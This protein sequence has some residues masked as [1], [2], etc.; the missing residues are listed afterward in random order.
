[1]S[2][3][4][5]QT[6]LPGGQEPDTNEFPNP[7]GNEAAPVVEFPEIAVQFGL[8]HIELKDEISQVCPNKQFIVAVP[9]PYPL[10]EQFKVTC[11]FP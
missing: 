11:L 9:F 5:F 4:S 7:S 1:M 3:E 8:I 10:D 2:N 6:G